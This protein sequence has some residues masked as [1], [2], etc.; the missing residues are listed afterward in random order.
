[1]EWKNKEISDQVISL[2]L[3]FDE[4]NEFPKEL[5]NEII[6]L[7]NLTS[8]DLMSYELPK[9]FNKLK[10]LVDLELSGNNLS[11]L[12]NSK[13]CEKLDYLC[14]FSNPVDKILYLKIIKSNINYDFLLLSSK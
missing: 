13:G 10:D 12:S 1:M 8:L 11:D 7:K 2:D 6:K 14:F 9:D 3:S 5:L 4:Y